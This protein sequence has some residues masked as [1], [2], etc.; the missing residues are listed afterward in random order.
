M[1]DTKLVSFENTF[2]E[3]KQEICDEN[4]D[5]M[6]KITIDGYPKDETMPGQAICELYITNHGDIVTAWRERAYKDAVQELLADSKKQLLNAFKQAHEPSETTGFTLCPETHVHNQ[7][8]QFHV[9]FTSPV[10]VKDAIESIAARAKTE[11][12]T[13]RVVNSLNQNCLHYDNHK[14][15]ALTD[16]LLC[17][18]KYVLKGHVFSSVMNQLPDQT[19]WEIRFIQ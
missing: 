19:D 2:F 6:A 15:K 17:V 3:T 13:I 7:D 9:V 1:S 18:P 14:T 10:T 16:V 12:F 8:P 4:P 11:H 5:V